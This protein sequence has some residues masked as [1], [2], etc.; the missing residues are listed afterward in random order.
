MPLGSAGAFRGWLSFGP[1]GY[2]GKTT[3]GLE[4]ML[5]YG[6]DDDLSGARLRVPLMNN[7]APIAA[8]T[9]DRDAASP[10]GGC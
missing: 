1:A 6:N 3:S 10:F 7:A 4:R 8:R 5:S 2:A 9:T